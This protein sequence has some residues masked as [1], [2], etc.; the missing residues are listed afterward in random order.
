VLVPTYLI[1]LM[2]ITIIKRFPAHDELGTC[3]TSLASCDAVH[4]AHT[5]LVSIAAN[6]MHA[7]T[8]HSLNFP[9]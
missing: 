7:S 5:V 9:P 6:A 4:L 1:I 2:I 3:R 8:I